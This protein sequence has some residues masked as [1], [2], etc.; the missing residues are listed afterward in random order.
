MKTPAF[1]NSRNAI[2][3]AL[4]PAS[5]LYRA[6][7]QLRTR[8]TQPVNIGAPVICIGGL[9][10]GGAGKT[11]VCL[12]IGE[13]C[14]THGI[15]AWFLSRGY[16]GR[17]QGPTQVKPS[18][19]TAYDVGD[20]PLLL[21]RVL[22]TVIAKDRVLGAQFAAK[23][24]AALIIMDDGFQ[25]PSIHKN[26]SIIIADGTLMFGNGYMIPA[27]PLREPV[28]AGLKR[29]DGMIIINPKNPAPAMSLPVL[30]ARTTPNEAAYALNGKK[31]IAFCGL[32]YP[33]KFFATLAGIGAVMLEE[34]TFPDHY[35]YSDAEIDTLALKAK[36]CD[37]VLVTT[38]KDAARM[39]AR[40]L[41]LVTVVYVA[42]D[43]E[44]PD[45]LMALIQKALTS[46]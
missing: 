17:L 31:V 13:L 28:E 18:E 34:K 1:W 10:A 43:F 30:Q 36:Q 46:S 45:A 24:G 15:N 16:K 22:P 38:S 11:P 37:A 8:F 40:S 4:L 20:E 23:A 44:Q 25:N 9:T 41:S 39:N 21:A 42:L 33:Q 27:G 14:K 35:Q 12:H 5:Y 32:A 29:A 7:T 26:L 3:T 19:H 6:I 2:A